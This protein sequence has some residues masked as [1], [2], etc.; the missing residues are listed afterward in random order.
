MND[1]NLEMN[2]KQMT[3]TNDETFCA[4]KIYTKKEIRILVSGGGMTNGNA[5]AEVVCCKND[6]ISENWYVSKYEEFGKFAYSNE[7]P[8]NYIIVFKEGIAEGE[9][10]LVVADELVDRD[11]FNEW[12]D[13]MK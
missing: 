6:E 13:S 11:W 8:P 2:N 9:F 7:Y 5:Y 1:V 12:C 10:E 4:Y 3:M